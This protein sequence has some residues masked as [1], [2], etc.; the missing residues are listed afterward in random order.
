MQ[1]TQSKLERKTETKYAV[2]A[3]KATL[4]RTFDSLKKKNY[5]PVIVSSKEEALAKIKEIIPTGVSVMSGASVT[6]EKIG[7]MEYLASGQHP[8]I[9]LHGK[10]RFENDEAK[11]HELRKQ[12]VHADYYLGSVHA[13]TEEGE[14]IIAS[15]TGSQLANIVYTSPNLVFVVST[16]KIVPD[17]GDALKRLE[18][19]VV[20]L[21]D[22]HMMDKFK[23]HTALNKIVTFKGEA[24]FLGRKIHLILVE[25]DLGF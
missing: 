24:S 1:T 8:W 14:M 7:Y 3:S 2:L 22:Q 19:Y 23:M 16:K 4:T 18:T 13:L 6:L 10:I 20:P 9:D 15:N 21:E 11:R 17:F 5:L 25:E 12:S